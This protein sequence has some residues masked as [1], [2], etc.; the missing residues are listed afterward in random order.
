MDGLRVVQVWKSQPW[1]LHAEEALRGGSHAEE[2]D[3]LLAM[4]KRG[5]AAARKLTRARVLLLADEGRT[6]EEI[7]VALHARSASGRTGAEA[8]RGRRAERPDCQQSKAPVSVI[9]CGGFT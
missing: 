6:D 9:R 3:A 1:R 4:V 8:L 7:T 2:R 5:P